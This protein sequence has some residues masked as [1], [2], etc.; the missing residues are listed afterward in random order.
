MRS[1]SLDEI[2]GALYTLMATNTAM[3]VTDLILGLKP[4]P[5]ISFQE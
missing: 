1:G 3:A 5:E 4:R 2:A